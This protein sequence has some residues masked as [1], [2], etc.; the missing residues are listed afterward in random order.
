MPSKPKKEKKMYYQRYYIPLGNKIMVNP[1]KESNRDESGIIIPE[2]AM[3]PLQRALV[4]KVGG[5]VHKEKMP[6]KPGDMILFPRGAGQKF[7]FQE[8]TYRMIKSSDA[9]AII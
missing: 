1:E 3:P 2:A 9:I 6:V 4:I 7:K 5:G 8:A